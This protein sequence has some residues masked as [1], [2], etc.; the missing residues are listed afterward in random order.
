MLN[1]TGISRWVTVL[2][3]MVASVG[4]VLTYNG[5]GD[6][7][8]VFATVLSISWL[9]VSMLAYYKRSTLQRIKALERSDTGDP[10][11]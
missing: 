10:P 5:V 6:L 2:A 3:L 9:S 1:T 8:V 4:V 7:R 11:E